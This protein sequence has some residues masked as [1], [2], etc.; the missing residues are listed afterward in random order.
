MMDVCI[1]VLLEASGGNLF[2]S[3]IKKF[4]SGSSPNIILQALED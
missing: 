3:H 4:K 1:N 2:I